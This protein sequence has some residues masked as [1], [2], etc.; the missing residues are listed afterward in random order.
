MDSLRSELDCSDLQRQLLELEDKLN[1][2]VSENDRLQR[3]VK[4]LEKWKEKLEKESKSSRCVDLESFLKR[5]GKICRFGNGRK[6]RK[7]RRYLRISE[8]PGFK[9]FATARISTKLQ[10]WL[11]DVIT[12]QFVS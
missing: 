1:V 12:E 9:N 10:R 5:A 7:C 6:C 11:L 8:T 4:E 2:A 3:A